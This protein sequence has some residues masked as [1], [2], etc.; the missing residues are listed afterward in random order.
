MFSPSRKSK[1]PIERKGIYF[2]EGREG[3]L[4]LEDGTTLAGVSF[5]GEIPT[6]GEVVFTTGM[7]GYP[8]SLTDP[9]YQG[10]ILVLSYPLIG[11][12]GVP[13][14]SRWE[15]D[16]IKVSGLIVSDYIDIPSH[17]ESRESLGSWL[18]REKIPA[19]I[20]KDTRLLV[21][22]I[23]SRGAMLGKIIFERD[24][25]FFD[26]NAS[27]LVAQVSRKNIE[28]YGK[29]KKTILLIDCGAKENIIR[30]LTDRG[31]RVMVVPWDADVFSLPGEF[32]GVLLSNGPGDPT[33]L[34]PT[35]HGVKK[36]LKRKIPLLGICLGN[37]I[38][39]L[40]AGG[41]TY[42]MKFGHRGQNQPC[43]MVGTEKSYL[44]T[45]NHGFAVDK[46]PSGFR[47]WFMNG[48]DDTNEGLMHRALPVMSVQFHPEAHPG[49]E[50]TDW[51][52]DHFLRY[53]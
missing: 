18:R 29:G 17:Y 24:I 23:R 13:D 15:S 6:S 4:V 49:P 39:A 41:K 40:A 45:Q 43:R 48:N 20:I 30:S 12:Y 47:P 19:L 31:V 14:L 32:H 11:N 37:Q 53:V 8:E 16:G 25:P 21:G 3:C 26:P 34:T 1:S 9:S 52:F 42:K 38:L 28:I 10:Q 35:I 50:D 46:I 27:N 2:F 22:K 51:V 7:V 5:G 33:M 44:T 36:I